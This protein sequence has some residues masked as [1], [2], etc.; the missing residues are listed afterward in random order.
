[1]KSELELFQTLYATQI[2]ILL[3]V[4]IQKVYSHAFSGMRLQLSLKA[5]EKV[6]LQSKLEILSFLA[7]LLNAWKENVYSVSAK[8]QIYVQKSEQPKVKE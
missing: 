5:L 1:M 8:T 6:L 2:S 7:I 3:T 4:M